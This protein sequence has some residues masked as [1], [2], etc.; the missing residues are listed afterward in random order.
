MSRII[1]QGS[2]KNRYY[3]KINDLGS[4]EEKTCQLI[5]SFYFYPPE[6]ETAHHKNI[7]LSE[8]IDIR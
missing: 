3:G 5:S 2:C 1:T 6:N 7:Y 4:Q 8:K